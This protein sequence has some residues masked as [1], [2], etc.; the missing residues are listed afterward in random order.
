MEWVALASKQAEQQLRCLSVAGKVGPGTLEGRL[1]CLVGRQSKSSVC[2]E[3]WGEAGSCTTGWG[4]GRSNAKSEGTNLCVLREPNK[5]QCRSITNNKVKN[6]TYADDKNQEMNKEE[7][8]AT[9]TSST[10]RRAER[11]G[12]EGEGETSS[13]VFG[14][15]AVSI[16]RMNHILGK[17][18]LRHA[19]G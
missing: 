16:G 19:G 6:I 10:R 12:G 15:A 18:A 4:W 13:S 7:K 14:G 8:V 1:E 3:G 9:R 5:K 11:G 2:Q 17:Q